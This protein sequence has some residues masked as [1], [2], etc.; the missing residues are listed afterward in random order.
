[1]AES[2]ETYRKPLIVRR[3]LKIRE[4]ITACDL[5]RN[6]I[7]LIESFILCEDDTHNDKRLSSFYE[8]LLSDQ[9]LDIS[10]WGDWDDWTDWGKM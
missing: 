7:S 3:A 1:M 8:N 2:A 6:N 9:Q 4:R 5:F 10:D